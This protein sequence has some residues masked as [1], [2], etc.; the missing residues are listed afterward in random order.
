MAL[1]SASVGLGGRNKPTDVAL[2]QQLLNQADAAARLVI[3]GLINQRTNDAIKNF[4]KTVVK[5]VN[6]DSRINANGGTLKALIKASGYKQTPAALS[7]AP[8]LIRVDTFVSLYNKQY[9]PLLTAYQNGLTELVT[10]ITNDKEINNIRWAAYMLATTMHETD[11]KFLPIEEYGKGKNYE[12]SEEIEVVDESGKKYTNVYYGRGYV[13]LTWA[14]N[15]KAIGAK[16]DMKNDLYIHPEKALESDIAYKI[17]SYGMRNGTFT[18]KKL[19]NYISGTTADYY[20][21]RRIINGLDKAQLIQGY[22]ETLE[23]LLRLSQNS[24][25]ETSSIV[26]CTPTANMCFA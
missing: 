19:L 7:T 12:Y 25:K 11:R 17:M 24:S 18:G 3:D 10:A 22:A 16:L 2:M 14:K 9:S 13:Q 6:P 15:Y 8:G 4:Q 21:A 23:Q 5:M 1:I 26:E 20:N